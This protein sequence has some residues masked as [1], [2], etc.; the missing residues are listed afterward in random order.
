MTL[1]NTFFGFDD[2]NRKYPVLRFLFG[3]RRLLITAD[4]ILMVG[5]TH[6]GIN[7]EWIEYENNIMLNG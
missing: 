1:S 7:G 3:D 4:D 2:E 6:W 5:L